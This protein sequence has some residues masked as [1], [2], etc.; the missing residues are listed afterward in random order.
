VRPKHLVAVA[1][2]VAAI[3]LVAQPDLMDPRSPSSAA[4]PG[5]AAFQPIQVPANVTGRQLTIGP[6]DPALDSAG[7]IGADAVFSQPGSEPQLVVGRPA[8]TQPAARGGSE[9]KPPRYTLS[10]VATFYGH[11]TTAMRLPRGTTVVICGKGG[12]VERIINDYGPAAGTDRIADLYT[13]DFFA[14]CGCPSW[15][16]ETWVTVSVY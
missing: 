13:K 1:A 15:S 14:I 6:L 16:G 5:S 3:A 11:G 7:R 8:V 2:L 9:L 10:G 4:I 12:C